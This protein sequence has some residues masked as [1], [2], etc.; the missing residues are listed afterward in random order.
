MTRTELMA[1]ANDLAKVS[2]E[3]WKVGNCKADILETTL[4]DVYLVRSYST[5]V[6]VFSARTG[7]MYVFDYYSTTTYKH[8]YKAFEQLEGDRI[9][10]L[11]QRSD[12][13]IETTP[14][15]IRRYWKVSP[16]RIRGL[17]DEGNDWSTMI[18][19]KVFER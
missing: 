16:C 2:R 10:W 8:I 18:E 14:R 5:I 11:Y 12:N 3:T 1:L 9:V 6:G 19:N 15:G 4:P 7:S 17:Q 13:I